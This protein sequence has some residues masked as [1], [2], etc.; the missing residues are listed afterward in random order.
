MEGA[1]AKNDF[2]HKGS[3]GD[4]DDAQTSNTHTVQRKHAIPHSMMENNRHNIIECCNK[5]LSGTCKET[6]TCALDLDDASHV[7]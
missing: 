6:S 3:I 1:K 5:G 4:E 2:W 7:T